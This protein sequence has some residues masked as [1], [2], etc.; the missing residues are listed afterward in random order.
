MKKETVEPFR[1]SFENEKL[2]PLAN[3][4]DADEILTGE[5]VKPISEVVKEYGVWLPT[6]IPVVI[7]ILQFVLHPSK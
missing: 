5:I 2:G 1:S 6:V 7:L 3:N 4:D